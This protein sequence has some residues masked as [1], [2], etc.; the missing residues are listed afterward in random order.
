[1][2][3]PWYHDPVAKTPIVFL[4]YM[5]RS[6]STLLSARLAEYRSIGVSI[7]GRFSK[8][9]T[10]GTTRAI[11]NSAKLGEYLEVLYKSR[12]FSYWNVPRAALLAALEQHPFPLH[13][14]DVLT[15]CLEI[16]FRDRSIEVCVYKAGEHYLYLDSLRSQFPDARFVFVDRNPL[17]IFNSQK[18]SIDGHTLKPMR[19]DPV[20]F[21]LNYIEAQEVVERHRGQG[22]FHVVRYENLLADEDR[23]TAA[24]LDFMGVKNRDKDR[25]RR[26]YESI[27]DSQKHLHANV[28]S[29]T[30]KRERVDGWTHE[31]EGADRWYLQLV[32]RRFLRGKGYPARLEGRLSPGEMRRFA[33]NM[34]R[35]AYVRIRGFK[36]QR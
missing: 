18:R 31:L 1:V 11:D 29:G 5:S 20:D 12:D 8:D 15:A 23:E 34:A 32:L 26:Y 3:V 35:H 4:T 7:E 27:P 9:W 19:T 21:V 10:S 17:A 6:G 24:L 25:S 14:A 28:K 2:G 22:Y 13:Y 16:S 36:P 33:V 30:V